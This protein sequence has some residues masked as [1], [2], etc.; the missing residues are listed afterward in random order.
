MQLGKPMD[1]VQRDV[2]QQLVEEGIFKSAIIR[3]YELKPCELEQNLE[4]GPCEESDALSLHHVSVRLYPFFF[5]R[6][7]SNLRDSFTMV[8]T[9]N[10]SIF[11]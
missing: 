1:I 3:G 2:F 7:S 4:P 5:R 10:S 6:A 8:F 9:Q 11:H